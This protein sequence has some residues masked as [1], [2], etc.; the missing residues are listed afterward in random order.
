MKVPSSRTLRRTLAALTFTAALALT[1]CSDD[2]AASS[3]G[4][5]AGGQPPAASDGGGGPLAG[6]E[7]GAQQAP[8]ADVSDVPDVVATVNGQEI[9]KDE[10]I[11]VYESQFQQMAMQQQ[12]T[13]EEVDEAALKDQVANQLVDNQLLLQGATDAGIEATDADVDATL[14]EIAQQNG[15]GSADEV[16]SAL[17]QQGMSEEDVRKDAA[18]QFTLT[19]FVEQKADIQEPTDEELQ[20]QYDQLVAQ[21]SQGAGSSSRRATGSSLRCLP[22][23]R[24]R[25]SWPS[26]PS[27]S[28]RT[29]R[30]APSPQTCARPGTSRSTSDSSPTHG[31]RPGH[32]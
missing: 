20:A 29:R 26:R 9:T 31:R 13:G 12:T 11:S 19:S 15:L 27:P 18:S 10:F 4:S 21:Q 6:G 3:G 22:S 23:R 32:P 2:Q 7:G 25:S 28:S 24:S 30:P 16:V 8:E 14:E 17:E 5:D 1:G